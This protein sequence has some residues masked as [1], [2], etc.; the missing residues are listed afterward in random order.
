MLMN[1]KARDLC[2][3]MVYKTKERV[4]MPE[5]ML[6]CVSVILDRECVKWG[7]DKGKN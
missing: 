5:A 7:R 6:Y 2:F 1:A 4:F 3:V